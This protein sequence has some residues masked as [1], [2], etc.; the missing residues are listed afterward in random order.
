MDTTIKNMKICKIKCKY[1]DGFLEYTNFEDV[2]LEYKCLLCNKNFQRKANEKLKGRLFNI[3]K[4][5][6]RDNN[7]SMLLMR[8][9][10]YPCE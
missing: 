1:C 4:F 5:S 9:G 2:L 7:N 8:K 3:Y 10:V 6:D